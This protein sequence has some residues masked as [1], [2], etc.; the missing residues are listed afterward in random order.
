MHV[1]SHFRVTVSSLPAQD[2]SLTQMCKMVFQVQGKTENYVRLKIDE[3]GISFKGKL[4]MFDMFHYIH[5]NI[6]RLCGVRMVQ[7][8]RWLPEL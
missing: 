1:L 6:A 5:A 3:P 8:V 4:F 2:T 7:T